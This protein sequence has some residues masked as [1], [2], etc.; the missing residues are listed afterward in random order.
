VSAQNTGDNPRPTPKA[1]QTAADETR[2]NKEQRGVCW[3]CGARVNERH[4]KIV[5]PRC[6]FMRDCSD[7]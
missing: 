4:C 3:I 5:C 1:P 2:D 6:G 7:P